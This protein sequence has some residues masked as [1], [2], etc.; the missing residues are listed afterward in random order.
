MV[1]LCTLMVAYSPLYLGT[2]VTSRARETERDE[3]RELFRLEISRVHEIRKL[4]R[5]SIRGRKCIQL[6]FELSS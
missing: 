3:A 6:H 1:N 5:T 2:L 4:L